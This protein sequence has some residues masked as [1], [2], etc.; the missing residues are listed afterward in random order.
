M[1]ILPE[2]DSLLAAVSEGHI[3]FSSR[4]GWGTS[5]DCLCPAAY[6]AV[7]RKEVFIEILWNDGTRMIVPSAASTDGAYE[8]VDDI[9]DALNTVKKTMTNGG[10]PWD[11]EG[12]LEALDEDPAMILTGLAQYRD[13]LLKGQHT[14]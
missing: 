1:L 5:L 6:I 14:V 2:V 11:I 8:A 3:T 10:A 7:Q 9:V 13:I 12:F 4:E